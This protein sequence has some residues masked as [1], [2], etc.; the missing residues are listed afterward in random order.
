MT[1]RGIVRTEGITPRHDPAIER[2]NVDT[3]NATDR[4][5]RSF[6]GT[7]TPYSGR[8][9]YDVIKRVLDLEAVRLP[10]EDITVSVASPEMRHR[11][12]RDTVRLKDKADAK[13][14]R[15]R[16]GLKDEG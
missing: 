3:A 12:K 9:D 5:R 10:F 6:G 13:L 4:R 7:R 14:L 2:G 15:R 11:M 16:F 1:R 8:V